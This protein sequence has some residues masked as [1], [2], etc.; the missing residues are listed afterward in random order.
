VLVLAIF[1][2][3]ILLEQGPNWAI[4]IVGIADFAALTWLWARGFRRLTLTPHEL[5]LPRIFRT[6]TIPLTDIGGVGMVFRRSPLSGK[7]LPL[8]WDLAIWNEDGVPY[9]ATLFFRPPPGSSSGTSGATA[10]VTDGAR[11]W[12]TGNPTGSSATPGE[13]GS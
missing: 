12:P 8:G 13:P 10:A 11:S 4:A 2:T 1:P 5:R 7:A 3:A 6:V 9:R